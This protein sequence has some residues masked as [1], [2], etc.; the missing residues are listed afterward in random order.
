MD[1]WEY[2]DY[3]CPKCGE[4]LARRD[5]EDCG[6]E[7]INDDLY[8]EDPFWYDEGDWEY[9]SNCNGDG[10]FFWCRNKGCN[11]TEEEI[12]KA[13]KEQGEHEEPKY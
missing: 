5:C 10:A 12:K 1:D 7:G 13:L 9:C 6:G 11:V 4:Q 3:S 8:E 2:S